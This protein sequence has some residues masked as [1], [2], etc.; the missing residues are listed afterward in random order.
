MAGNTLHGATVVIN[1][2]DSE[3]IQS[4]TVSGTLDLTA[5][6]DVTAAT[7]AGGD[8][9]V[10][11]TGGDIQIGAASGNAV[12]LT[13]GNVAGNTLD[14]A[15]VVIH[16]RDSEAIQSITVSGSLDL[17][18]AGKVTATTLT[19]GDLDVT[20]TAADIQFGT[21]SGHTV[22]FTAGGNVTGGSLQAVT[23]DLTAHDA[24][25][26]QTTNAS[27]ELDITAGQDIT[28]AAITAP[29]MRLDSTGGN[30]LVGTAT[31]DLIALSAQASVTGDSLNVATTL[32]LASAQ[33]TANVHGGAQVV[34][35]DITGY[36]GG[37]AANVK[38][39]LDSPSGFAFSELWTR[40]GSVSDTEGWISSADTRIGARAAIT[41]PITRVLVDQ[42]DWSVQP[43]DVQ[44]Y[45]LWQ[46]FSFRLAG[47][48]VDSDAY[49][50]Y[51]GAQYEALAP[52][53]NDNSDFAQTETALTM[54]NAHQALNLTGG[55][56]PSPGSVPPLGAPSGAPHLVTYPDGE[57][58]V[59]TEGPN[60]TEGEGE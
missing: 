1:A 6:G 44:L 46:P 5:A 9:D 18:A 14:G 39:T 40:T 42:Y 57:I 54:S 11:S 12:T 50:L 4:I 53:G 21:A 27:Q 2:R 20:S 19:G 55:M 43:C 31:G 47:N 36:N 33:I 30:V 23:A 58:P 59:A 51:R 49:V 26:V 38:L 32:E 25:N 3:A 7:L 29:V 17:T 10:T 52:S 24:V 15:Q 34:D 13:G 48:R 45:S 16:A 35:G 56:P 60:S 28:V 22:A 8:L 41:N 37:Q